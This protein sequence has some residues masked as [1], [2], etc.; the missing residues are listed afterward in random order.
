MKRRFG[1]RGGWW[2]NC[3]KNRREFAN[4]LVLCLALS[5]LGAPIMGVAQTA[6]R[7]PVLGILTADPDVHGRGKFHGTGNGWK[8]VW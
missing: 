4:D 5:L 6:Q 3:M 1:R 2:S 8:Q 7:L